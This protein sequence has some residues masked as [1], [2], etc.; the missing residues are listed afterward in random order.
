LPSDTVE[1]ISEKIHELE[2]KFVP[3]VIEKIMNGELS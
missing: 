1:N 2:Q 3:T